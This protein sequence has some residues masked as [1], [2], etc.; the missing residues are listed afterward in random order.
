M[1]EGG[2]GF[3]LG[4][5]QHEDL[6]LRQSSGEGWVLLP[7]EE[8]IVRSGHGFGLPSWVAFAGVKHGLF[9]LDLGERE[10]CLTVILDL[11]PLVCK[12]SEPA[13]FLLRFFGT[14]QVDLVSSRGP[15]LQSIFHTDVKV[16]FLA[17]LHVH[18]LHVVHDHPA[19][20]VQDVPA[21]EVLFAVDHLMVK[22]EKHSLL[23]L[24][25]RLGQLGQ[26]PGKDQL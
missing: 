10:T 8:V 2:R 24:G 21:Q 13:L 1:P 4:L 5:G 23:A 20:V 26:L 19:L 15:Q 11:S 18:H 7:Q 6:L 12:G 3:A 14:Q 25:L 22:E 16:L 9:L 17:V